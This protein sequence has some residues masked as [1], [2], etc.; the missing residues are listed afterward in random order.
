MKVSD[1]VANAV[2]TLCSSM[3]SVVKVALL[4]RRCTVKADADPGETLIILG[5]GPSLNETMTRHG[6]ELAACKLMAVNYAC[7]APQF[8]ALKPEYY[9]MIDPVFYTEYDTNENVRR[10]WSDLST[11][12]DWPMCIYVP[13]KASI[14]VD[15]SGCGNVRVERINPVGVEGFAWLE[16]VLFASGRGMPRPRNVLIASLMVALKIG[17]KRIFIVGA[18]HTWTRT[19]EVNERNEVVSVQPHFY[20][21]N[22]AENKRNETVY[23]NI[24][25]HEIMYSFHVAFKSYFAIERYAR[26]AGVDIFNATPGSFIDAFRRKGLEAIDD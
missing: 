23:K 11:R 14:P 20:K 5:N 24:R 7:K 22:E 9:V 16:N 3:K 1:K 8:Y 26:H 2:Q 6:K 17:F 12:V 19:L 15:M 21:D 10:L 25:L 4:S 13:A 18:D